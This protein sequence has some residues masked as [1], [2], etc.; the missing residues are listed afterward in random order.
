M[1]LLGEYRSDTDWAEAR[2][3]PAFVR[4]PSR[5]REHIPGKEDLEIV[6]AGKKGLHNLFPGKDDLEIT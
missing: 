4:I 6:R 2:P 1:R 5:L 3:A